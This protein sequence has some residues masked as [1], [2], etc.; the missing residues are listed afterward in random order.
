M[1]QYSEDLHSMMIRDE[2]EMWSLTQRTDGW[3]FREKMLSSRFVRNN[4]ANFATVSTQILIVHRTGECL[5][6]EHSYQHSQELW[7]R[8]LQPFSICRVN[9]AKYTISKHESIFFQVNIP[10]KKQ[11]E[12][13]YEHGEDKARF[14]I[15]TVGNSTA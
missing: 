5:V 7:R 8:Y 11:G 6:T 1:E 4:Y 3:K 12:A 10:Q 14:G 9:P 13:S 2:Q 15:K